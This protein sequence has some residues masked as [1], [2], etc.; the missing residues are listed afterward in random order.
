MYQDMKKQKMHRQHTE[1]K[2][3]HYWALI[4]V[5]CLLSFAF[6]TYA[7]EKQLEQQA[8]YSESRR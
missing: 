3:R 2:K 1:K 4:A 7:L 8:R 6:S 5:T